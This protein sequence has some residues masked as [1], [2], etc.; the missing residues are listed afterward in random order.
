MIQNLT[1][2]EAAA[3]ADC[4]RDRVGGFNSGN[5][6]QITERHGVDFERLCELWDADLKKMT[7]TSRSNVIPLRGAR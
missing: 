4:R 3:L 1:V 7:L 5:I 6:A 2:F